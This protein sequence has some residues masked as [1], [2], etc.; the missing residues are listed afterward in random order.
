[1]IFALFSTV[2]ESV[3]NPN[4]EN[5]Y[6]GSQSAEPIRLVK[7]QGIHGQLVFH[8]CGGALD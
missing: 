7:I 6:V 1:M 2:L 8:P 4:I 5:N 3:Q